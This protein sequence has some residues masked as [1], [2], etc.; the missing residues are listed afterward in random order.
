MSS[1]NIHARSDADT[2]QS[3]AWAREDAARVE[4]RTVKPSTDCASYGYAT[5]HADGA[6]DR[7]DGQPLYIWHARGAATPGTYLEP[8]RRTRHTM[9]DA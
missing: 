7:N 2:W 4:G 1:S 9:H 8:A 6:R 3:V 5:G